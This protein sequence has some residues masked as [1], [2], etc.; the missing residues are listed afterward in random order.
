MSSNTS[1]S[2]PVG[3]SYR[4]SSSVM[5]CWLGLSRL[6]AWISLKLLTCS[7]GVLGL[8]AFEVV[9]VVLLLCTLLPS[10]VFQ[11]LTQRRIRFRW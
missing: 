7:F 6:N 2:L 10:L 3:W 5:T 9:V 4:T 1:A 11:L 8:L